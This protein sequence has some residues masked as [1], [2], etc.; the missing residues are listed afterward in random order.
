MVERVKDTL[1]KMKSLSYECFEMTSMVETKNS[2]K[3]YTSEVCSIKCV[4]GSHI[5]FKSFGEDVDISRVISKTKGLGKYLMFVVLEAYFYALTKDGSGKLILECIGSVGAGQNRVEMPIQKQ[6]AFFRKFGFR[7]YGKYSPDHIHMCL[8]SN[9][10][11]A[12]TTLA[13]SEMIS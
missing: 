7:K 10:D 13:I 1:S 8:Q 5:N 11:L 2:L 6:T 3:V 12:K 4:D 9:D